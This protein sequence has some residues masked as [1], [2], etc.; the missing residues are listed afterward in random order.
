[1]TTPDPPSSSPDLLPAGPLLGCGAVG[2][3]LLA[4]LIVS[5]IALEQLLLGWLYFPFRVLPQVTVDGPTALLGGVCL[6]AFPA[7]LHVTMRW[8][9]GRTAEDPA[10][11]PRRWTFRLTVAGTLLLLL[12]FAAGTAMVGVTHQLVWLVVGR[13][14]DPREPPVSGVVADARRS[15]HRSMCKNDLR[16]IGLA[17]SNAADSD[18]WLPPGGTMD[19]QG[20]LLHGWAIFLG[21]YLGYYSRAGIDFSVPWNQSPNAR[22]YRCAIPLYLNPDIPQAFDAQ[23]YGLSHVAGNVHVLPIVQRPRRMFATHSGIPATGWADRPSGSRGLPWKRSD[24]PDGA[25]HTLLVGQVAGNF[26]PWGHP[27]N[28]RDPARGIGRTPHGFAGPPGQEGAL[29]VSCDGS[30]RLLSNDTSPAV[31]RALAIPN[32]G[33]RPA[34]ESSR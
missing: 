28:V 12:L 4:L 15:A 20:R 26:L 3:L 7:G 21:E 23:G 5:P 31:L 19:E 16:S 11:P 6:I 9:V 33:E 30:V 10:R 18:G 27:A 25:S 29:F 17:M 8:L 13:P 1:M 2:V 22:L 14:D 34:A 24:I 32:S